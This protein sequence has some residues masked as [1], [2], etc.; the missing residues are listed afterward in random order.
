[1]STFMEIWLSC[2][3]QFVQFFELETSSTSLED[4][5]ILFCIYVQ[6]LFLD[7]GSSR[8]YCL[9]KSIHP[10]LTYLFQY[11]TLT[12]LCSQ[13]TSRLACKEWVKSHWARKIFTSTYHGNVLLRIV[14]VWL[15]LL[16][17]LCLSLISQWRTMS[18]GLETLRMSILCGCPSMHRNLPMLPR[19]QVEMWLAAVGSGQC[20]RC[21]CSFS[22]YDVWFYTKA[23]F[24]FDGNEWIIFCGEWDLSSL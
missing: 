4:T 23:Y 21:K 12:S 18:F 17:L 20:Y 22:F 8:H 11:F 1:M 2:S 16:R 5:V 3:F 19:Q 15:S 13:H 10:L 24:L 6:R 7:N 9:L 14:E